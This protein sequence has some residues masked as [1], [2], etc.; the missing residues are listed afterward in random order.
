MSQLACRCG[1]KMATVFRAIVAM[2]WQQSVGVEA[3][4]GWF[5]Q[6]S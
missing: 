1:S 6:S 2:E 3:A 5:A 4:V